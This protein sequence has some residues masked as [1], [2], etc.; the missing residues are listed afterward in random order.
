MPRQPSILTPK[1]L[2]TPRPT[3]VPIDPQILTD[4]ESHASNLSTQ[5]TTLI[6]SLQSRM[7]QI[8]Q[9]TLQ[10]TTVHHQATEN[11]CKEVTEGTEKMLN[12]IHAI[13]ELTHDME[14][15]GSLAG[16]IKTL[17]ESLDWLESIVDK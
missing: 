9:S 17:K 3:T 15:V 14:G 11:L 13:D 12:L 4:I 7:S 2:P 8:T 5:I 10:S 1:T 16:Q 6:S